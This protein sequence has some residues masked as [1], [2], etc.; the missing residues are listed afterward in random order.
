MSPIVN[1]VDSGF[2]DKPSK[3]LLNT[4]LLPTSLSS[5]PNSSL[6]R[7]SSSIIELAGVVPKPR[8]SA[9]EANH[10]RN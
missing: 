9:S 1:V 5:S 4:F 6:Y 8:S 7:S 3:T 2:D 10:T